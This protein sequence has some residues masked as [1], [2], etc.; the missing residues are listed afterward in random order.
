VCHPSSMHQIN[1]TQLTSYGVW[2]DAG[3]FCLKPSIGQFVT[4]Q[5]AGQNHSFSRWSV[6]PAQDA[7]YLAKRHGAERSETQD[8]RGGGAGV[9]QARTP[10]L[11]SPCSFLRPAMRFVTKKPMLGVLR[12]GPTAWLGCR[13]SRR[14]M[15]APSERAAVVAATVA[16]KIALGVGARAFFVGRQASRASRSRIVDL[17]RGGPSFRS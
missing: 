2:V 12:L 1:D 13:R 6:S 3:G 4:G 7:C 17:S 5:R 11:T 16:T 15:M 10:T 9:Q 8:E 14:S